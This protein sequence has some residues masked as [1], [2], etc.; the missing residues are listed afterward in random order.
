MKTCLIK[1][2]GQ[3]IILLLGLL[4]FIP[5][6][7]AQEKPTGSEHVQTQ[8]PIICAPALEILNTL[9]DEYN[10]KPILMGKEPVMFPDGS[11]LRLKIM[12]WVNVK[13]GTYTIVQ[14]PPP[15][16]PLEGKLCILTAGSIDHV[17]KKAIRTLLGDIHI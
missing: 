9:K 3:L 14:Q 10:E 8:K 5:A 12:M 17:D 7:S 6:A 16:G 4:S 1:P 2:A 13:N 11:I 15:A